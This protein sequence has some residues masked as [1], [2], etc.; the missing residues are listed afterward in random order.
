MIE[1]EKLFQEACEEVD[2]HLRDWLDRVNEKHDQA[3]DYDSHR[4]LEMKA[5]IVF[6]LIHLWLPKAREKQQEAAEGHAIQ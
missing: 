5:N 4:R 3:F 1:E 2:Q 6:D